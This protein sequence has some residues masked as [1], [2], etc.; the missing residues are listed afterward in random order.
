MYSFPQNEIP[1]INP[2]DAPHLELSPWDMQG[3]IKR[4]EIYLA[5]GS[6]HFLYIL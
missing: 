5:E 3:K 1:N 4:N 2:Y 6:F